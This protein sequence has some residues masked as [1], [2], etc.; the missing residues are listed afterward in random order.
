MLN[1]IFTPK[2]SSFKAAH[3]TEGLINAYQRRFVSL[4]FVLLPCKQL[5][6]TR[7]HSLAKPRG[8]LDFDETEAHGASLSKSL[9]KRWLNAAP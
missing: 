1:F 5:K 6:G 4:N 2:S 9:G 8:I 7:A 3:F